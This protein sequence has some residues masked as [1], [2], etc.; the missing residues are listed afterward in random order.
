MT[1]STNR[2]YE[3]KTLPKRTITSSAWAKASEESPTSPG[4]MARTIDRIMSELLPPNNGVARDDGFSYEPWIRP[5]EPCSSVM[6][7]S[8]PSIG[9]QDVYHHNE[10]GS[11]TIEQTS[12]SDRGHCTEYLHLS[13]APEGYPGVVQ[14]GFCPLRMNKLDELKHEK[15]GQDELN[16]VNMQISPLLTGSFRMDKIAV[17]VVKLF[18]STNRSQESTKFKELLGRR[19]IGA[20]MSDT[21]S[22]CYRDISNERNIL[23]GRDSRYRELVQIVVDQAYKNWRSP[24]S[25]DELSRFTL[26]MG[27]N[28]DGDWYHKYVWPRVYNVVMPRSIF[29]ANSRNMEEGIPPIIPHYVTHDDWMFNGRWLDPC[30]GLE[31]TQS[32]KVGMRGRKIVAGVLGR[33]NLDLPGKISFWSPEDN[34]PQEW[35]DTVVR[36]VDRIRRMTLPGD[37]HTKVDL[38]L[39]ESHRIPVMF[40]VFDKTGQTYPK[41]A[42]LIRSDITPDNSRVVSITTRECNPSG[43]EWIGDAVVTGRPNT[44]HGPNVRS[45][46]VAISPV[47]CDECDL[48]VPATLTTNCTVCNSVVCLNTCSTVCDECSHSVCTVCL[49]RCSDCGLDICRV[50]DDESRHSCVDQTTVE[51]S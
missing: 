17:S 14:Y 7:A 9:N 25:F 31:F 20:F 38:V 11:W 47:T 43:E 18:S 3:V 46:E 19:S 44:V 22:G 48:E 13:P 35:V 23:H 15:W 4:D 39:H 26:A 41:F 8:V 16:I 49:T 27:V 28:S 50:C 2:P 21:L 40:R 33:S 34:P 24:T 1:T 42:R 12:P 32:C 45:K 51:A 30:T 29:E 36:C 5:L 10:D 37:M 6:W